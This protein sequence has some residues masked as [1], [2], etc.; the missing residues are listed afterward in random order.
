MPAFNDTFTD[1]SGTELS[2]HASDS[3]HAWTAHANAG[4]GA[5]M[6]IS[7]ANRL[8]GASSIP[9]YYA[10]WVPSQPVFWLPPPASGLRPP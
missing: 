9:A 3:G 8:R 10:S 7:D 4:G 1:T 5:Q 2:L 6:V